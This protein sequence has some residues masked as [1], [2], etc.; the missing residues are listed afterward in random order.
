VSNILT[1]DKLQYRHY[2][3]FVQDQSSTEIDLHV[4]N[5][6]RLGY[7]IMPNVLTGKELENI[8]KHLIE[9]Y[10][11]QESE[12]GE[13]RLKELNESEIH[14]GLL[15]E[16][17]RYIELASHSKVLEIV[18]RIIGDS[19]ILNLQNASRARP[20]TKHYQSAWHRDFAK[21]FVASKCLSVNA[22]WCIS[23]FGRENG[24]TWVLP[25]SHKFSDFPSEEHIKANGIQVEAPAGSVI[26]WDSLLLHR[27]GLNATA[28]DRFGINHMYTRPFI[29]QQIDFP[30]YLKDKIDPDSSLGQ[31]FGFWSIPPKSVQEFRVNPDKRTYRSGQG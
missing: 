2:P 7:S 8:Q 31:L 26:F 19:A 18:H 9:L 5:I 6:E 11:K 12:F 25:F 24:A 4:E 23:P 30:V 29:K 28:I 3:G 14:R 27:A 22:F 13:G 21:D 20:D 1:D 10:K 15:V 16:D 17:Q